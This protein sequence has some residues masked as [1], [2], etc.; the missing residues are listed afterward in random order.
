LPEGGF[1]VAMTGEFDK[2]PQR[3]QAKI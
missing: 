2:L 1:G 3:A